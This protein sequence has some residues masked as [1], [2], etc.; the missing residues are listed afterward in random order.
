MMRE[1]EEGANG[2]TVDPRMGA[3]NPFWNN[4][5]NV[6]EI[7]AEAASLISAAPATNAATAR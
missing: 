3:S 4:A 2:A 5:L 6:A 7:P 1:L